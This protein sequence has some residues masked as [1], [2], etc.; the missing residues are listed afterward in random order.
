M[1][2]ALVCDMARPPSNK[3]VD[4]LLSSWK[5]FRAKHRSLVLDPYCTSCHFYQVFRLSTL[6]GTEAALHLLE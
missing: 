1:E 6:K 2:I 3:Y 4:V 5:R